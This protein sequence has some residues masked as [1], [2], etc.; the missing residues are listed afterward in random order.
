MLRAQDLDEKLLDGLD[1]IWAARSH[2][3]GRGRGWYGYGSGCR[4]KGLDV[5]TGQFLLD[6]HN[7][8]VYINIH[9]IV[10]QHHFL[11]DLL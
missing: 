3:Y 10:N 8:I 9:P 4:R 5:V 1:N 2:W 11:L 6:G 7:R